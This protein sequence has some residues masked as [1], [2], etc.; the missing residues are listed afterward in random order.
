MGSIA[1]GSNCIHSNRSLGG[2][3]D[4]VTF[5]FTRTSK[6]A[7]PADFSPSNTIIALVLNQQLLVKTQPSCRRGVVRRLLSSF[8]S[9][10][11]TSVLG[12]LLPRLTALL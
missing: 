9:E 2:A 10:F 4:R 11:E 3:Q 6:A 1:T 7:Y 12:V 8:M 5:E